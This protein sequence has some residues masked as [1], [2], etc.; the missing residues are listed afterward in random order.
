MAVP[1]QVAAALSGATPSQLAYWRSSRGGAE[2]LLVP[3]YR[4]GRTLLYSFRDVVALRTFA[5]LREDISLQKVREAVRTL[6]DIGDAEHLSQYRLYAADG[7]VVWIPPDGDHVDLVSRPGQHRAAAVMGDVFGA[8]ENRDGLRVLPLY[9][10][11]R[12]IE[13]HPELRGGFPVVRGTRIPYDLVAGLARSGTS[14]HLVGEMYPSVSVAGARDAVR[15]ADYVDR[16]R[17]RRAA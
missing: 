1:T 9:R 15:M 10:P 6:D 7:S 14:P 8:F 12:N 4:D 16:V 5:Y 2:P 11:F 3:E 17:G 13:V